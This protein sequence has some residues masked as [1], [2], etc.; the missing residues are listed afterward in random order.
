[1]ITSIKDQGECGS[2]W[3]FTAVAAAES[4]M[5]ISGL[6]SSTIDLSEQFLLH[7]TPDSDCEGGF[8]EEVMKVVVDRGLPH[9][10]DYPYNPLEI[11]EG[12]CCSI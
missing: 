6:E 3:A 11:P 1:V 5:I 10:E 2:C 12:I 7:C 4:L 9:E 8:M